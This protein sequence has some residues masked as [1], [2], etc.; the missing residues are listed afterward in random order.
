ML[1]VS[2]QTKVITPKTREEFT[3]S[4][5]DGSVKLAGRD[6]VFRTPTFIQDHPAQGEEHNEVLQRESDGSQPTDQQVDDVEVRH[7]FWRNSGSHIYRHHV[8][9]RVKL[10]VPNEGSF[11]ELKV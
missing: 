11:P 5:A 1:E 6:Q 9:P 8:A 10:C 7:D 4:S 3:F 2:T